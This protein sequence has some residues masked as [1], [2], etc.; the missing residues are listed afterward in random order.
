[1]AIPAIMRSTV[2]TIIFFI[3]LSFK[4]LSFKQS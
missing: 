4:A 1:M 3:L 2:I